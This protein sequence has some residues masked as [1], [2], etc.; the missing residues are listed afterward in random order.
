MSIPK[1]LKNKNLE[2]I[3]IKLFL[4]IL[5]NYT[6]KFCATAVFWF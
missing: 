4:K 6:E 3:L 1:I 2:Q 5:K